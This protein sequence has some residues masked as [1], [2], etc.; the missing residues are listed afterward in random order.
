[1][2]GFFEQP[3]PQQAVP[4]D[5]EPFRQAI[6]AALLGTGAP[7]QALPGF[8][9][10]FG[11]IHAP[12]LSRPTRGPGQPPAEIGGLLGELLGLGT[13]PNE[14]L[15]PLRASADQRLQDQIAENNANSPG[16]FSSA[17]M[18]TNSEL[19]RRSNNDFNLLSSQVL[20]QGR[21]RQLQAIMALLGPA[22]GPTFGGPFIQE[23]GGMGA[24][25]GLLDIASQFI[26]GGGIARGLLQLGGGGSS[27]GSPYQS[28][29]FG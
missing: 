14:A 12:G 5:L 7:G 21:N 25:G 8:G 27:G 11:G 26:P 19:Q 28:P 4:G 22:I 3:S 18:Y 6:I 20:E 29:S 10:A 1:M 24:L 15:G 9:T 13:N 2:P 16:R 17:Q 23:S